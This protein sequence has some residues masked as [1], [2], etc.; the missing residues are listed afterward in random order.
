MLLQYAWKGFWRRR[1]RSLLAVLGITLSIAL[2]VTV[3]TISRA[4][5]HAVSGALDAAG[6]DMVIQKRVQACPWSPVKLP[7]DLGAIDESVVERLR[8]HPGVKEASGVLEMWAF[9]TVEGPKGLNLPYPKPNK[10]G[11]P[12]AGGAVTAQAGQGQPMGAEGQSK[13]QVPTVVAGI[14]P[15]KKTIGPVRI[16]TKEEGKEEK[17]CCAIKTG[18]YLVTGDDNQALVTEAYAAVHGLVRGDT[19]PLGPM[20]KFEVVGIVDMG[21]EAR[22]A[23]AEAFVPLQMAQKMLGQGRVVDTIFVALNRKGDSQAVAALAQQLIGPNVSITT[24]ANVEAG[25][26]ALA[27]VTRN[28]LLAI[29]GLVLVFA[30]LL[31]THSALDNVAQRVNEVGIMKAIGWRNGEV[32]RLFMAEA[33]Y[34]GLLGGMLGSA[35][36]SVAGGLYGHFAHL[37]LPA[38]LETRPACTQTPAQLALTLSTNPSVA[39]FV[40]GLVC[41]LVIGTV[42]GLAASRRAARL[43]PVEALR[44]L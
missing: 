1:T 40:M 41:A 19:I 15:T 5:E 39:V 32:G 22:I 29:S 18:R 25:T 27:S 17:G 6:A 28:S 21:K 44:R 7:K 20:E 3:V 26:A 37:M 30:L 35:I 43:N 9:Y 23:G 12:A 14:D 38:S 8:K 16:A 24:A 33:A 4:V 36:G 42:A 13:G 34:A 10:A 11:T 2:L 31:L